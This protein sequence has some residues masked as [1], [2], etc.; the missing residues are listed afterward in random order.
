MYSVI[1]P[2]AQT[3][4][5]VELAKFDAVVREPLAA[6]ATLWELPVALRLLSGTSGRAF[7]GEIITLSEGGKL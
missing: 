3:Q 2:L 4:L 1:P 6:R 7:N 5:R